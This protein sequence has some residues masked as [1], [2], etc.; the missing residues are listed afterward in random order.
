MGLRS[1]AA[2]NTPPRDGSST[3]GKAGH[4]TSPQGRRVSALQ[5][6]FRRPACFAVILR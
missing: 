5:M 2:Q 4:M 6:P 1:F 3:A